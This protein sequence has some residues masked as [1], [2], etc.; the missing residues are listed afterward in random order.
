M[1]FKKMLLALSVMGL[2]SCGDSDDPVD[3]VTSPTPTP[4]AI[5][6]GFFIDSAVEGLAYSSDSTSGTTGADG[7]FEYVEGES[8]TFSI[9]G[10][11]I[12]SAIGSTY[13]TPISLVPGSNATS[14]AVINIVRLLLLLDNDGIGSNGITIS[15]DVQ[16]AAE[17]WSSI[18]FTD[19]AIDT[20]LAGFL[21]DVELADNRQIELISAQDAQTHVELSYACLASGVYPGTF[22]GDDSGRFVLLIEPQRLDSGLFGDNQPRTGITSATIYSSEDQA[23]YF[24][25]FEAGLT[26][27]ESVS[28]IAGSLETGA[29]FSGSLTDFNTVS[30]NW[31][32]TLLG[33][34]GTFTGERLGGDPSAAYRLSGIF[35]SN[36]G[37]SDVGNTGNIA[38]DIFADNSATGN[39]AFLDG[40]ELVLSGSFNPSD[41]FIRIT[42]DDLTITT[43]FDPIGGVIIE[44]GIPY[45]AGFW[46]GRGTTG[47]VAGFSCQLNGNP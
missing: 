6:T 23:Y 14:E 33:D 40:S 32:N 42:G 7:S 13:I 25:G 19:Q 38:I 34:S 28:V 2:A 20:I 3:N 15:A 16:A 35:A 12:G 37:S 31:Q 26:F 43:V 1:K 29:Q 30:G 9:G 4:P 10:L 45:F 17:A 36:T 22:T 21:A 18:S 11:T 27:D 47:G 44:Q 8:I 46:E 39:I 24:S 41:S 5:Q